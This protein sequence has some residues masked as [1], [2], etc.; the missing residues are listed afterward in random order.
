MAG[1][2]YSRAYGVSAGIAA[3]CHFGSL[4]Q[5]CFHSGL[6][7]EDVAGYREQACVPGSAETQMPGLIM[8]NPPL[9]CSCSN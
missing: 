4:S 6:T 7:S 8:L 3:R 2:S 9:D 5:L 1:E